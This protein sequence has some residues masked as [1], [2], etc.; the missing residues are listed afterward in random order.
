MDGAN[1]EG[2]DEESADV[3][4][5]TEEIDDGNGDGEGA[6][7]E[8]ELGFFPRWQSMSI[9]CGRQSET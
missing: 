2:D 9:Q 8:G 6:I 1:G 7:E 4:D 5:I 3:V